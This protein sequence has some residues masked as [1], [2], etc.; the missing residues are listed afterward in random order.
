MSDYILQVKGLHTLYGESHI[1]HGLSFDIKRGQ[2][3]SI[4]GRNGMGKSTTLKSILGIVK[5]RSG[6]VLY[7][8]EDIG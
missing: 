4:M 5:P 1:L 3:V 7:K 2:T 6:S 8:G